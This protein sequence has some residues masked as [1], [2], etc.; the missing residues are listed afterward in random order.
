[1]V[2]L[3]DGLGQA[4]GGRGL[5]SPFKAA[6]ELLTLHP[7][8]AAGTLIK[9]PF[10]ILGGVAKAAI[11]TVTLPFELIGGLFGGGSSQA[12]QQGAQNAVGSFM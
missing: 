8:R 5:L 2:L 7:L 1:M 4:L 11:G 3:T 9:A 10:N 6:G 12:A